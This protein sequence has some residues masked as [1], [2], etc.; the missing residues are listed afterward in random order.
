MVLLVVLFAVKI[1]ECN[2]VFAKQGRTVLGPLA[3]FQLSIVEQLADGG[4]D[5]GGHPELNVQH[6]LA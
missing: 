5:H 2:V 3:V 4:A 6:G 1:V